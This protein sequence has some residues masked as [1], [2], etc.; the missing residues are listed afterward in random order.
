MDVVKEPIAFSPIG[1]PLCPW[2][3]TKAGVMFVTEDPRPL[4]ARANR[5][6]E[7]C[8]G[9][10]PNDFERSGTL[11][12][13]VKIEG[14]NSTSHLESTKVSKNEL[15]MKPKVSTKPCCEHAKE[16]K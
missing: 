1:S 9:A 4:R 14:T 7:C 8:R 3:D 10:A 2:E 5:T 13:D 12:K 15:K 6:T 11:K 16:P